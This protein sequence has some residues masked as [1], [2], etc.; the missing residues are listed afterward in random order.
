MRVQIIE[1]TMADGTVVAALVPAF[2]D[3][4]NPPHIRSA[5]AFHAYED[6]SIV[7]CRSSPEAVLLQGGSPKARPL[8]GKGSRKANDA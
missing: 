3:P 6:S 7:E 4:D 5:K 1:L 2:A 8:T